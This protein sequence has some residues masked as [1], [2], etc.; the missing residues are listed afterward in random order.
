M[1]AFRTLLAQFCIVAVSCVLLGAFGAQFLQHEMPCP[2]CILQRMGMMLCASGPAWLLCRAAMREVDARDYAE[3]YGLSILSAILGG[4]VALRQICLHIAPGDTGYGSPMF[5]LHLYTWSFI[6][7]VTVVA[8]S[9]LQLLL[10]PKRAERLR[11]GFIPKAC[12]ALLIAVVAANTIAVF[13]EEGFHLYLP[14]NP[15]EYQLFSDFGFSTS[16]PAAAP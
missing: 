7:F 6:V 15:T 13:V 14:D 16:A 3:C 1:G 11:I 12:V 4:S 5:G 10:L 9:G 8:V 2:L